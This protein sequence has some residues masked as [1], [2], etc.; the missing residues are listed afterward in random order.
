MFFF[1]TK[2]TPI[3]AKTGKG[4]SYEDIERYHTRYAAPL[5]LSITITVTTTAT[6]TA[7]AGY[8]CFPCVFHLIIRNVFFFFCYCYS[9]CCVVIVL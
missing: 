5:L 8:V 6:V 1:Y 4:D 9:S 3:H 7:L 2:T